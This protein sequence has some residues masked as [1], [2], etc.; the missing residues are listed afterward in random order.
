MTAS[1]YR[2]QEACRP[3]AQL[4]DAEYQTSLSY[5]TGT[6]RSGVSACRSVEDLATYLAISGMPWDPETFVLVEVDADLADV[7]DED[8]DLGA[9]LVIPTK[10]I[11][12]TPVMDT[13]LLDLI[14]AAFAA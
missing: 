9:R 11:A 6:E 3:V 2:I 8:H 1:Y 5:C 12:V 14:D 7:E 10:I 13:G 4:L